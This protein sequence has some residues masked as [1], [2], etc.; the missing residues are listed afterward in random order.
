MLYSFF[1]FL[2]L[3][4]FFKFVTPYH[5][6]VAFGVQ[7][8]IYLG[9]ISVL[10][11]D[12]YVGY[13][14]I[15]EE[16]LLVAEFLTTFL[17]YCTSSVNQIPPLTTYLVHVILIGSEYVNMSNSL[18]HRVLVIETVFC[19]IQFWVMYSSHFLT[20]VSFDRIVLATIL[21]QWAWHVSTI[22]YDVWL[23]EYSLYHFLWILILPLYSPLETTT[24]K[25]IKTNQKLLL[26]FE[27]FYLLP[28]IPSGNAVDVV[29][30]LAI[31]NYSHVKSKHD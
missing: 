23:D 4:S 10:I 12:R 1:L 15:R 18:L 9:S 26:L 17:A 6:H 27:P 2:G 19:C 24:E 22:Y 30:K 13:V 28:Q 11:K 3:S 31:E 21:L 8:L 5:T 16:S 14:E 29:R 20:L 7:T 25:R